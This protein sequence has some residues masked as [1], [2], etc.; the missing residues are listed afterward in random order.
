MIIN[1]GTPEKVPLILGN[2]HF[3]SEPRSRVSTVTRVV[4][5]VFVSQSPAPGAIS[6]HVSGMGTLTSYM[7]TSIALTTCTIITTITILIIVNITT[8]LLFLLIIIIIINI[9]SNI[10]LLL[11]LLRSSL[12]SITCFGP[13]AG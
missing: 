13:S 3:G 10:L 5:E 9:L 7:I 11:L 12:R 6:Y 1:I 2:P 4:H 8:V